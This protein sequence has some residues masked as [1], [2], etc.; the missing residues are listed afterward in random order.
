MKFVDIIRRSGRNLRQAKV[1]TIL[2]ALAIAVGGFTLTVTLAAAAGARIYTDKLVHANFDPNSVFVAKDKQFFNGNSSNKPREYSEDLASGNGGLLKQF[3]ENDIKKIEQM[4]H[5]KDVTANYDLNARYIT[6][7]GAKKYTGALIVYD[8]AQKPT[9]VAG[10]APDRLN[11]NQVLLSDQYISLLNFDTPFNAVGKK[12][13][14]SVSQ[15]AGGASEQKEYVIVGITTRSSLS[16]DLSQPGV[17]ISENEAARLSKFINAN[18]PSAGKTPTLVVRSD[19]TISADQLKQQ[20]QQA[21]YDAR[22]AKDLQQLINQ[23][24]SVLQGIIVVFGLIT[25]AASFFGVVNTQYISVLERT[26]EIGLMKAL[27]MSKR[28]VSR[29][30][31]VEAT[32]I[33]FIGAVLGVA[34]AIVVGMLLNPWISKK[35]N[36]GNEHLLIFKPIQIVALIIFLMLITT[37]A[38][39]LPARKA[40]KLDPIEA[41]RTE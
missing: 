35:L 25:L 27:G 10:N 33:G 15:V 4:P 12:V 7:E 28:A 31:I 34:L 38:G 24:I 19:G 41:L 16:V 11:D 2:T 39:L 32:W 14:V 30:F 37:I 29:L 1:R 17:Y 40:A 8:S 3:D 21:G 26:R 6:R 36:F 5:V 18:T 13:I 22:T 9:M 20:M 23:V